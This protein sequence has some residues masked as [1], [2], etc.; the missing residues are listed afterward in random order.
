MAGRGATLAI[1]IVSDA[2]QASKGFDEAQ[3][4]VAGFERGLDR[5]SVAA[6]GMLAGLGALAKQ[7]YDAASALEQ[8]SGA[9]QSVYG[10]Q[11]AQVAQ[12][13]TEAA[14]R[15]GLAQS[16]YQDLAAVMGSQLQT[17]GVAQESLVPT[18]NALMLTGAD[19]AA[20]FGGDTSEAVSALSSL[21][22]GERDP[23]ERYGISMSQAAVDARV[24]AMGLDTSTEAAKKAAQTQA[25]L[26]L[27]MEQAGGALGAFEREAD[28]AAGQTQ[29]AAAEFTNAKAALGEALLPVV[30]E[31]M[32]MF[33][34]LSQVLVEHRGTVLPLAAGVA[35]LAA[36]VL[37][38]NG[39]VRVFTAVTRAYRAVALAV[40][41]AQVAWNVAMA[42]NPIGLL[43]V[44][45]AAVVAGVV[46]MYNK[47]D[48]FR[49]G[50][51]TIVDGVKS[52]IDSVRDA[53]SWVID[54]LSFV[55]GAAG[56]VANLFSA[57]AAV[58]VT[59]APAPAPSARAGG[60]YGSYG[61]AG[62]FGA[63]MDALAGGGPTAGQGPAPTTVVN[64]WQLTVNGA[65]DA[66]AVADQMMGLIERR[67]R[68]TGRLPAAGGQ[69]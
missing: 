61:S 25:T 39:A 18:M 68:R 21:L 43:V 58:A 60:V 52:Y 59:Y 35:G 47:F 46:L 44:A 45:I 48:W 56:R 42:A 1:Q 19:L 13:S 31:G 49:N 15:M 2:S 53:I 26:A 29:R 55:S 36:T 11:A 40:T 10:A 23:I 67:Q 37:A 5:A 41:I 3:G 28:T 17:L 38:V 64:N 51:R 9:V 50:V 22:R 8:S 66:A 34:G 30:A 14:Q 4:R 54:K 57:P 33:A 65:L 32:A 20:T 62:T 12:L 7:A 16:Q 69:L 24:A 63:S 6:G 27:V